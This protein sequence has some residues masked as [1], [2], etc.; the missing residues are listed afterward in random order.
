[1]FDFAGVG[2]EASLQR[3]RL[4]Y[5]SSGRRE[6][7]KSSID[8]SDDV[9]SSWTHIGLADEQLSRGILERRGVTDTGRTLLSS[10]RSTLDPDV[11]PDALMSNEADERSCFRSNNPTEYRSSPP[12]MAV[13][14]SFEFIGAI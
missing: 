13:S 3:R 9:N 14:G 10:T 6:G 4:G 12:L 5:M 8:E 7:E 1:V 11:E 2:T